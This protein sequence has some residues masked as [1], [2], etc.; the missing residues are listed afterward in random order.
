M[1]LK[2]GRHLSHYR[3]LGFLDA[4]GMGDV[5]RAHDPRLGRDVAIKVLSARIDH[6]ER[7]RLRFEREARAVASVSHPNI[8]AIHDIGT[9]SGLAFTV[10][11]LLEGETLRQRLHSGA[12]PT[13]A[14]FSIARSL[15]E[16]LASAH[17]RG[18]VHR[19]LKPENV[20]LTRDG[21]V[22]ILDFGVATLQH[23]AQA[24]DDATATAEV[25]TA[26]QSATRTGE[27]VGT[28][29]Y[30][31][32]EQARGRP[33]DARSDVF[34]FGC[35]LY[36][37][38]TGQAA[39]V[40]DSPAET[41]VALLREDPPMPE[42]L[43]SDLVHIAEQCLSK[44]PAQR[45]HSAHD[46]ALCLRLID[47]DRT[48]SGPPVRVA[49]APPPAAPARHRS[50]LGRWPIVALLVAALAAGWL[51]G[52]WPAPRKPATPPVID[53]LTYTGQD[54][55]PAASHDGK[56]LAFASDRD[57]TSRIWL[58]QL[59]GG[60]ETPITVGP[61]RAPRFSHDDATILFAR[62]EGL[63]TSLYRVP[64]LGGPARKLVDDAIAGDFSPDDREIAF[65]R[66]RDAGDGRVDTVLSTAGADGGGVRVIATLEDRRL[67]QPRWAPGRRAVALVEA[68]SATPSILVVDLDD[69]HTRTIRPYGEAS[70]VSAPAWDG[71][72]RSLT[73]AVTE[74]LI[75]RHGGRSRMVRHRGDGA[76]EILFWHPS[77]ISAV[78]RLRDDAL[79]FESQALSM[80]LVAVDRKDPS[81]A[82]HWL[83]RGLATDRQPSYSPNGA[84][85]LFSSNRSGNLDLWA[86]DDH[87]SLRRLTDHPAADWDPTFL[88]D[89][90]L[91]WS[92]R[93]SGTFEIWLAEPDGTAP[94]QVTHDG[95]LAENPSAT[96]DGAWIVYNSR[97][98]ANPGVLKI[99]LDGT[100]ATVV[101]PGI[102]R[103]PEVSPDGRHVLFLTDIRP[104]ALSLRVA[105]IDGEIL[106][107]KV[108]LPASGGRARWLPSG[109]GIA[110]TAP[111]ENGRLG[112]DTIPFP[113]PGGGGA[114]R[115]L[116]DLGPDVSVDS[117]AVGPDG[118][119]V[120][121]AR[122]QAF[123]SLVLADR[124]AGE[125]TP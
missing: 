122:E 58:K 50:T 33:V 87:G 39:F 121:F 47:P 79:V 35:V 4:G 21:Q 22:K 114:G 93:R 75:P 53:Y 99:R 102:T 44:E 106:P 46:L 54:R 16:G 116:L 25:G 120:C 52:R 18:L 118:H 51:A 90:R 59:A 63:I 85:I 29:G 36:E 117:F 15:A 62:T 72:G 56:R 60:D 89:G 112:I 30:L 86:L 69:G 73:F 88:A 11:E 80:D 12:L 81:A 92:S 109:D 31:S 64:A 34:A 94:R 19:D 43:P 40:R 55:E 125:P 37:M 28:A 70:F 5:Y 108:A 71:D 104:G 17:A 26:V 27:I 61:D 65:V 82:E 14:L 57:G 67:V 45:F 66:W 105:R 83:T 115:P 107:G 48:A 8:L 78:E 20:F 110:Y 96:P 38:L 123:S 95:V 91:L 9:D 23:S 98:P 49:D 68:E 103:L 100:G 24:A 97:N 111:R 101:V 124:R 2:P 13:K 10:S 42:D 113:L 1:R 7:A 84:W 6:D 3:I 119:T 76:P 74:S 77:P 32:P 41:L